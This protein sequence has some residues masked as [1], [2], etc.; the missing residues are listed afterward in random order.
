MK[1]EI[2]ALKEQLMQDL[3]AA[4]K[5]KDVIRKNVVTMI[6][7]DILQKEKDNKIELD[8]EGIMDVISKQLKQRKD[9]L[10]EF[11]KGKRDDL[12][13]QTKSEIALLLSYLPKQLSSDELKEIVKMARDK[14]N[15]TQL[16]QIG[17]LMAEVMPQVKG[18]AD[19]KAVNTIIKELLNK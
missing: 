13:A 12:V 4:M 3:K 19:G 1:E 15:I 16:N 14:L 7:A 17:K 6:R 8:D 2:M 18:K 11:T 10:E 5:E 9:A